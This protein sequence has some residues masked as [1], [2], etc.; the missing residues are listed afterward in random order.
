MIF[1]CA[2]RFK[3]FGQHSPRQAVVRARR[4]HQRVRYR[5]QTPTQSADI[6]HRRG[7]RD[8]SAT[9]CFQPSYD[10]EH[11]LDRRVYVSGHV[12]SWLRVAGQVSQVLVDDKY[13]VKKGDILVQI[14]KEPFMDQVAIKKAVV[15]TAE[16]D[17]VAAQAQVRALVAQTRANRFK[18]DHAIEDVNNR[19]ANLRAN[20]ATLQSR[21]ANLELAR[22][23]LKRGEELAPKGGISKEDLDLRRQ[24]L[25]V[26]EAAVDEA[27]QNVYAIRVGLGLPAQPVAGQ[28]L[29]DVPADLPQTFSSV[30]Q[31]VGDLMQSAA[32]FGYFGRST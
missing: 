17:M 10:A 22:A 14:D 7:V 11:H 13:R 1:C 23:N 12:T 5:N 9:F 18:L 32:Q 6:R 29:G 16:A 27:L 21:K 15:A 31:A 25:K 4:P 19:T 28:D 26:A 8:P 20:V 24:A 3:S 30:R 2:S